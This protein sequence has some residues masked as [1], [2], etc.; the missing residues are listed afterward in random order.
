MCVLASILRSVDLLQF[1]TQRRAEGKVRAQGK[2]GIRTKATIKVRS[3]KQ[4]S[5][6]FAL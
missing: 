6:S 3:Q 5:P 2:K 1:V 4:T